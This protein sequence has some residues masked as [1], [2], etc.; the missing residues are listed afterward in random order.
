MGFINDTKKVD[1]IKNMTRQKPG[2]FFTKFNN[3][4]AE[5]NMPQGNNWKELL[6]DTEYKD[7]SLKVIK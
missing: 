6:D 5:Q 7:E 3:T 4:G 1:S 2:T